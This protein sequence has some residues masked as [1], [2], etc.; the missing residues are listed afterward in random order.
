MPIAANLARKYAGVR[1]LV[2]GGT[3]FVGRWVVRTLEAYG[4]RVFMTARDVEAAESVASKYSI[5]AEI[6]RLDVSREGEVRELI[7]RTCPTILFN[8][9]GY[10]IDRSE[11]DEFEAYRINAFLL[12]TLCRSM[13][14]VEDSKWSGQQI[15]HTGSA[16]EY[17]IIG[18]DLNEGSVPDPT[19]Q[20][21]RSKLAGTYQLAHACEVQSLKGVTARLFT[22]YGAG[23]HPGRLLPTLIDS[24]DC[25]TPIS[26]TEGKQERDFTYVE[27]VAEGLLRLGASRAEPG[28]VVN[29][30]TGKL[31]SVHQFVLEAAR[32]LT[33][34]CDRLHF[35]ALPSR[36]D[37]MYHEEVCVNRLRG[38]TGWLPSTSVREGVG[39]TRDFLQVGDAG[40]RPTNEC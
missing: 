39:R 31:E 6:H 4:A 5:A 8:L 27:D 33:I 40:R 29:L 14:E 7:R 18:G 16:L 10:G 38:L 36:S 37:D 26:L 32:V 21:G 23:E 28:E 35:G 13:A 9:V 11:R 24:V 2:L 19:T 12:S 25:T 34:D 15:V 3:G 20:Y 22:V 30:A 17:G 1:A